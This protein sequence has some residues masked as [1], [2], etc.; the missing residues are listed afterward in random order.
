[1]QGRSDRI[2]MFGTKHCGK[3]SPE[4]A[5]Y[6]TERDKGH[7]GEHRAGI[8]HEATGEIEIVFRWED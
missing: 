6:C 1:M 3:L 2:V 8:V 4:G 5:F 7:P